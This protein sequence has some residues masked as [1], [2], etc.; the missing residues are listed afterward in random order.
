MFLLYNF[1]MKNLLH[2]KPTKYK[3]I[4]L[5][6]ASYFIISAAFISLILYNLGS[7]RLV[8]YGMEI[9]KDRIIDSITI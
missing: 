4:R 1:P 6:I 3:I 5:G 7:Q 2:F 8:T 9:G